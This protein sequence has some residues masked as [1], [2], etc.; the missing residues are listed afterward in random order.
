MA[1]SPA[2]V[3]ED[4]RIVVNRYWSFVRRYPTNGYVDNA[5]WQAATFSMDAFVRFGEARDKHRAIQLFQWLR[6]HYPHSTFSAQRRGPD[7]APCFDTGSRRTR[8]GQAAARQAATTGNRRDDHSCRTAA[9]AARS[10][11]CHHRVRSR[12]LVL[13]GT[14]GIART[15]VLRSERHQN[16]P[17]ACRRRPSLRDRHRAAHSTR[18]SSEQHDT[19]RAGSR[20]CRQATSVFTLYKPYRIVIDSDRP[21]LERAGSSAAAMP[22]ARAVSVMPVVPFASITPSVPILIG[23]LPGLPVKRHCCGG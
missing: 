15:A 1:M 23:S 13:P 19:R 22:L 17:A 21:R 10:G 2:A 14:A 5:L 3:A 11:A 8:A 18:A 6:D 9:G 12:N 4:F 7:R 20:E 16:C